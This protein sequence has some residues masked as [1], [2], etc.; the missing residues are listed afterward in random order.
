MGTVVRWSRR[1]LRPRMTALG[2]ACL[3]GLTRSTETLRQSQAMGPCDTRDGYQAMETRKA[4]AALPPR[5]GA[6]SGSMVM[7]AL[8]RGPRD[9]NPRCLRR[10]GRKHWKR[11]CGYHRHS[12]VETALFRVQT[13]FGD[14]VHLCGFEAQGVDLLIRC[15]ALNHI[16]HL[17][18]PDGYAV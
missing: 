16:T 8:R 5:C 4:R 15:V 2:N 10:L 17:S 3:S 6:V 9:E 13:I 12:L 18:P 1:W 14:R 7:Q 11:K